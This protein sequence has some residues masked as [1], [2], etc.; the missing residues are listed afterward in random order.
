MSAVTVKGI[1]HGNT[2]QLQSPPGL[3]N[4]QEVTVTLAPAN[5]AALAP[6]EGLKRSFGGW[7]DDARDLDNYLQW[8]RQQR[9][10]DRRRIM[11]RRS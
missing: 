10:A 1:V 4:G 11:T 3:P 5:P 9:K 2:I 8:A 6:G 7:A